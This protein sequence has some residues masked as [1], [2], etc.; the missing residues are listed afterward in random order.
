MSSGPETP[1]HHKRMDRRHYWR[2]QSHQQSHAQSEEEPSPIIEHP[3][4]SRQGPLAVDTP[5]G[6]AAMIEHLQQAGQFAFDTEFIGERTYQSQ[7]C[8]IQAATSERVFVV[9]ALAGLDLGPF[10]ELIVS[11]D[12]QKIVLAGQQD[13]AFAVQHTGRLPANVTDVQI[14]AGFVHAE[15]PLSLVRLLAQFLGVSI[16]KAHTFTHWD[17]RPLSAVQVRYAGDDVRY[18]PAAW[19]MILDKLTELGRAQWAQEESAAALGDMLLYR[20][21]PELIYT[22]VRGKERLGPRQLAVLRELAMLRDTIARNED[23]PPRTVLKDPVL[24]AMARRP[25]GTLA[26]LD[27]VSG[28]PRPI[29]IQYGQAIVQATARALSLPADQLPPVEPPEKNYA[30]ERIDAAWAAI[31]QRCI[32]NSIAPALA[33]NRKE[34]TRLYFTAARKRQAADAIAW[35][36]QHRLMRGWRRELFGDI[37]AG[38]LQQGS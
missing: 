1:D 24:L 8:L 15:Y 11:P 22:R 12:V 2:D 21:P 17:K 10:W 36:E 28:L 37:V 6:L 3:L 38:L 27:D 31:T 25:A 33:T 30:P 5:G 34:L 26:D 29:E 7:L 35:L 20:S 4:V 13:L 16:G 14:A 32:D 19:Q 18:L 23:L 9:D